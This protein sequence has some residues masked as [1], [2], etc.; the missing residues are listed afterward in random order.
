[1][2]RKILKWTGYIFAAFFVIAIGKYAADYY[3]QPD[4]PDPF[5]SGNGRIEATEVDV[6]SKL[7]GR[8]VEIGVEEGK[9]VHKGEIVARL[10]TSELDARMA[11]S[12]AQIQQAI[13]NKKYALDLVR[14]HDS[15]LSFSQKNLVR[16]KNLY[17]NNNISLVQL[18][19]NETAVESMKAALNAAK[20]QVYAADAAIGAAEAQSLT[21]QSNLNDCILRS[22]IN[23]QVLYKLIEPGEVIGSGGKIVTLL[24]LNDIY[25]TIFVPTAYAGRI[26]VG[27]EARILLDSLPDTA[28]AATVSFVSPDAQ[29]TPKEIETQSEREKLMFR[30]KVKIDPKLLQSGKLHINS[31]VPG[32]AYIR[33]D[34]NA[35]WPKA[36]ETAK[37]LSKVP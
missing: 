34:P 8:V 19:Q 9:Y 37:V 7:P 28:I 30:I 22:P 26:D 1:M 5:A 17:I 15:E 14:Q 16:S 36:V 3:S 23:G 33:L 10:D 12:H 6:A 35:P 20:S 25:M 18:Q 21:I 4:K 31:G 11:Q 24:D 32:T 13:Q 29:F 27:S 2:S